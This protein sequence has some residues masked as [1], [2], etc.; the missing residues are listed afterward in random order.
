MSSL[1][2]LIAT[3]GESPMLDSLTF[4]LPPAS[5]AVVDRR[6]HVRAYP[7]SVSTLALNGTRSCRIRLGGD[8]FIDP[9]SVRLM[10][11][12]NEVS[13]AG[14]TPRM[15]LQ[16]T[17][18]PWRA[19]SQV[20]LRSNGVELD[21]IP[22]Y[23]RFHQQFGWNQLSQLE[24]FGEAGISGM[25]GSASIADNPLN[26]P[27]M[28]NIAS[29]TSYTVMHRLYLS[30]FLQSKMIPT[31]YAPLELELTLNNVNSDWLAQGDNGGGGAAQV[32]YSNNFTISNI[33]V[34]Y[35]AYVLDE[36]V[37]ESFYR[38]LL[39]SRVRSIPTVTV[40][41]VSNPIMPTPLRFLSR[42]F[43]PS[44]SSATYGSRSAPPGLGRRLSS[45]QQEWEALGQRLH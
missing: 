32:V 11:T 27:A 8:D 4:Q 39:L 9:H 42:P 40:Y 31:R 21:N 1:E 33:M 23:G 6:Q 15:A 20:Y 18:G 38:S 24:H 35:D 10:F 30:L 25:A 26:T 13:A 14:Q 29:G 2:S 5:T 41:M 28:G 36:T 22:Q 34:I 37:Q 3:A 16:P 12:I 19:W 7:S 43:A 45:A 44:R 17:G